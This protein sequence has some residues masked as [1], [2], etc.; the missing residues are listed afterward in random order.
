MQKMLLVNWQ[1]ILLTMGHWYDGEYIWDC[2]SNNIKKEKE[3]R[4][5]LNGWMDSIE[6]L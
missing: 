3:W 5:V 4:I 6:E 1:I 2:H